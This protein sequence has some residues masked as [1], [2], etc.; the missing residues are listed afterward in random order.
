VLEPQIKLDVIQELD[1]IEA[2]KK[3]LLE[4]L[5]KIEEADKRAKRAQQIAD[6]I[7]NICPGA[8]WREDRSCSYCGSLKVSDA[9]SRLK[10][11]GTRFSGADWKYGWPHK[12]YIGDKKFYNVHLADASDQEFQE[13]AELSKRYFQ[14]VWEKSAEGISFKAISGIQLAGTIGKAGEK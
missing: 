3:Q 1:E 6:G 4:R 10:T 2:R 11:E 5:H 7:S 13:F 14:V 9:I 12:F 8:H